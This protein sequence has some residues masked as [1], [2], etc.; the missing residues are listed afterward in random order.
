MLNNK[1]AVIFDMDGTLV[2]S[3][4]IW[5]TIDIEYLGRFQI[6]L[7]KNLQEKIEGMSFS[8]TAAYFKEHFP[9][10]DSIETIKKDW[11]RMA[12]EKYEREVP[13]KEGVLDLLEYLKRQ[14]IKI[15]IATSNSRELTDLIVKKQK[16]RPYLNSVRTSCEA[17]RGKPYPDIYLLVAEDLGVEPS[18]CL[19]FE[20]VPMGILAGKSAGMEVCAVY[21]A[22]SAD[23]EAEKRAGA[24]YYIESFLEIKEIRKQVDYGKTIFAGM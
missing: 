3:M 8:E 9:I 4:W 18:E 19:V 17:K 16:L 15:G 20:D 2:D 24:D 1:K 21:D 22:F 23:R 13:L 5:K 11:N 12:W 14:E 6:P 7:P 10:S